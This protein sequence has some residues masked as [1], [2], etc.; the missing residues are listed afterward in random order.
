MRVFTVFLCLS[1]LRLP[2]LESTG[3]NSTRMMKCNWAIGA[4]SN[5]ELGSN[6]KPDQSINCVH[7]QM[8]W[9]LSTSFLLFGRRLEVKSCSA[10]R[11][12]PMLLNSWHI[13]QQ[14]ISPVTCTN[15]RV[16]L[17]KATWVIQLGNAS[18]KSYAISYFACIQPVNSSFDISKSY[19]SWLGPEF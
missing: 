13:F 16:P 10:G 9:M 4:N 15:P 1:Q 8:L 11:Y 7:H 18:Q 19:G 3:Y 17:L 14:V 5:H 12:Y 6:P 2:W